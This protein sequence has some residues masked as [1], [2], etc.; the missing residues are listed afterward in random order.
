MTD[1]ELL[2][3]LEATLCS[4]NRYAV[5]TYYYARLRVLHGE[6]LKEE[7][8]ARLQRVVTLAQR[9]QAVSEEE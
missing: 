2:T 1:L 4:S 9:L 3:L 7:Q 8:R 6:P 5:E